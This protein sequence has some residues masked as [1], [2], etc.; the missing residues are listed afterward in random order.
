[1]TTTRAPGFQ[2]IAPL[3]QGFDTFGTHSA[4]S[5]SIIGSLSFGQFV[6]QPPFVSG[7]FLILLF[8]L[9]TD[10]TP[11]MQFQQLME[12]AQTLQGL[13]LSIHPLVVPVTPE[14]PWQPVSVFQ[15]HSAAPPPQPSP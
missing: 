12:L 3:T 13:A 1:M 8:G 5:S 14:V 2:F 11:D 7:P 4:E 6:S 10:G 9:L 15:T